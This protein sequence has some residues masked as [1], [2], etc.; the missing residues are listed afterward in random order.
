MENKN[1]IL[2]SKLS[3]YGMIALIVSIILCNFTA[4]IGGLSSIL[5]GL[6]CLVGCILGIASKNTRASVIGGVS[7]LA[8]VGI[9]ALGLYAISKGIAIQ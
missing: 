1:Y 5:S 2:A 9:L 8:Y 3:F 6:A 7:F 4:S